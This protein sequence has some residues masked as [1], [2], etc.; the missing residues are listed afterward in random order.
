MD[1]KKLFLVYEY[2][3]LFCLRKGE[4]LC[5]GLPVTNR[6]G[7][8]TVGQPESAEGCHHNTFQTTIFKYIFRDLPSAK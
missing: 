1:V 4:E 6:A 3:S 2:T 7:L 8:L 5:L